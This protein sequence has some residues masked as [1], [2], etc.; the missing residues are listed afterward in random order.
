[1]SPPDEDEDLVTQTVELPGGEL[2]LLQP[3]EAAELPDA[4][5]IEWAPLVDYWSVLWRSGVALARELAAEDLRGRRVVELGCGLGVPSLA[6]A[7]AGAEVL[8]TDAYPEPLE[9]LARNAAANGVEVETAI[10]DWYRPGNLPERGPFD[11]LL[12]ADV[13]YIDQAADALLELLPGLAR[14]A[15]VADPGRSGARELVRKAARDW[16][17]ESTQRGVVEIHRL[18]PRGA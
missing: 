10:A 17:V 6:A 12:A 14:Q 1:L 15:M 7:R 4:G 3:A 2:R 5:G 16:D 11:L 18:C 13:L 9:L 8:A